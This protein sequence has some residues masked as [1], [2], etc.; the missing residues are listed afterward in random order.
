MLFQADLPSELQEILGYL[1]GKYNYSLA[2]LEVIPRSG[3]VETL[4]DEN[5]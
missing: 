2:D 3:P 1:E 4:S 5:S